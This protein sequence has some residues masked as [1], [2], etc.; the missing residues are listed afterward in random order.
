MRLAILTL[1][2]LL[3][4]A[5]A[6]AGPWPR[7]PGALFLSSGTQWSRTPT[8]WRPGAEFLAEYGLRPRLVLALALRHG[9]S[10]EGDLLARWHPPDLPGGWAW[11]LTAGIRASTRLRLIA[12]ADIGRGTGIRTGNLWLRAGLRLISAPGGP[13]ADLSAQIGLRGARWLGMLSLGHYR[14]PTGSDTRWRPALGFTL[15][16]RLTLLAE[17][18]LRPG[19]RRDPRLALTLW[20]TP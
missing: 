14:T 4:A 6:G 20:S 16:P 11:G 10:R 15:S 17:A 8:G 12:G 9:P 18:S 2:A 19:T 5:G 3:A 7:A 1:I 13:D